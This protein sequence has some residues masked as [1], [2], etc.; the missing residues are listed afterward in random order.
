MNIQGTLVFQCHDRR[1]STIVTVETVQSLNDLFCDP[2]RLA[3]HGIEP[4]S[5]CGWEYPLAILRQV[6]ER[7]ITTIDTTPTH[8]CLPPGA[9]PIRRAARVNASERY[10]LTISLIG[11]E[12]RP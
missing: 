7:Q 5:H 1:C 10:A 11:R 4:C 3:L 8:L 2:H 12:G 9:G 6:V